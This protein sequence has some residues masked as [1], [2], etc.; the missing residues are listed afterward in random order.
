MLVPERVL[1]TVTAGEPAVVDPHSGA[2]CWLLLHQ[3]LKSKIRVVRVILAA[4]FRL[5][6]PFLFFIYM[7]A[8]LETHT[9]TD[10]D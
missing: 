2:M 9:H 8:A 6:V 5:F 3:V 1:C 10:E 4:S 7:T